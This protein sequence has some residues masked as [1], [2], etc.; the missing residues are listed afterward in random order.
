MSSRQQLREEL[1][2][3]ALELEAAGFRVYRPGPTWTFIGFAREVEGRWCSATVQASDF[4]NSDGWQWAARIV[5]AG[6]D[7]SSA[8]VAEAPDG[9]PLTVDTATEVARPR[10]WNRVL[11]QTRDNAGWPGHW[12]SR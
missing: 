3:F 2:A 1:E 6:Q 4:G 5:P 9:T 7:G 12:T 8:W 10:V 11:S